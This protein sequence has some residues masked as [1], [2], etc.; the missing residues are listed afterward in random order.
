MAHEGCL[1]AEAIP[2][3][4]TPELS[5]TF[6]SLVVVSINSQLSLCFPGQDSL[7]L[8]WQWSEAHANV[9]G[10][11]MK[12]NRLLC[13]FQVHVSLQAS[14][15]MWHFQLW[16]ESV[17]FCVLFASIL[18]YYFPANIKK[19][20]LN[21]VVSSLCEA[22]S[23]GSRPGCDDR[24]CQVSFGAQHPWAPLFLLSVLSLNQSPCLCPV[25]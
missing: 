9:V 6:A 2:P 18:S 11:E 13:F 4:I 7:E 16:C 23:A 25:N 15:Q 5:L 8:R 22:E 10:S 1:A 19:E 3:S 14:D 20:S 21:P 12:K 17:S 24:R